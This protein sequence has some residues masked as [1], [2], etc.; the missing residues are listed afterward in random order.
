MGKAVVIVRDADVRALIVELLAEIDLEAVVEVAIPSGVDDPVV[1]VTD[2]G[3]RFDPAK[4]RAAMRRLHERWPQT[5]VVLLTSHR[6]AVEEPDQLG[7]EALIL[8]PFDMDDLTSA[9]TALIAR[10]GT[11]EQA[12]HLRL[13]A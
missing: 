7:A 1:V 6:A 10:S 2:L 9:V 4:A 5:P 11:R 12:R 13:E 8:K 3:P